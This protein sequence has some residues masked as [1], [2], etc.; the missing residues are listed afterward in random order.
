MKIVNGVKHTW[1]EEDPAILMKLYEAII[2]SRMEC[3]AF[4]FHKLKKKQ[5][6]KLEKIK[7]AEHWSTGVALRPI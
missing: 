4:L 3:E 5:A 6:Q 1:W 7:Y 2:R